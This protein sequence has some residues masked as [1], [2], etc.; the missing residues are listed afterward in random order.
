[1]NEIHR[2]GKEV[3][4]SIINRRSTLKKIY[5]LENINEQKIHNFKYIYI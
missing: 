1:M 3:S 2:N 4:T 5:K